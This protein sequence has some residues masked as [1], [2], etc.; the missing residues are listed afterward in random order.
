MEVF[1][2][3]TAAAAV[4][5][6]LVLTWNW[7]SLP[8]LGVERPG[9]AL[10]RLDFVAQGAETKLRLVQKGLPS[11]GAREAHRKGW[12][13]CLEGM[14]RSLM[15][16]P[17]DDS[18]RLEDRDLVRVSAPVF[19]L[20]H[21]RVIDGTGAPTRLDQTILVTDGRI[22]S[23]GDSASAVIPPNAQRLSFQDYSALPGLVGMHDH[24]FYST[25]FF[26]G[27]GVL[28]H[29]MPFSFPRLYLAAGVT[30]IRTAGSFEPYTDLEIEKSIAAGTTIGPK[31]NVTGPY[32]EGEPLPLI[33]IHK[34]T[35]PEHASRT[36]EFW[37]QE[38]VESFKVYADVTR[39]E[40]RAA[41][42]AA[43]Q[44][45]LSITGHLCSIGFREAAQMGIDGLEH[46]LFV[47][48]EFAPNKQPDRCPDPGEATAADLEL[49]SEAVRNLIH[50]L[51]ERHVAVTSTLP[52]WEEFIPPSGKPP[53]RVLRALSP[54]A[55][56]AYETKSARLERESQDASSQVLGLRPL[57]ASIVSG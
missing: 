33:Q 27:D 16:K 55:R 6:W 7:R 48:T 57:L 18:A 29:D 8:I 41:I 30:T 26:A 49:G 52:V 38:G 53:E 23:V 24:L 11:V 17:L 51:V 39:A 32:L 44:H 5:R 21:V 45:H 10:V 15:S 56:S 43:H 3:W 12:D 35:G 42:A 54:E 36:V 31:M 1:H 34:L 2:Q 20:E 37:A 13:R 28:A 25:N 47:D 46:G 40:L 19:A 9:N 14:R 4:Q 22:T 50:T